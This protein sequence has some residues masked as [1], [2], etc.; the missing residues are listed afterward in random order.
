[1]E[2]TG[3]SETSAHKIQMP[4]NHQKERIQSLSK[5]VIMEWYWIQTHIY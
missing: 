4:R 5:F 1:M 3:F 2:Q